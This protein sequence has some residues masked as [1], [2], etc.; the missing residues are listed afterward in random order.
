VGRG[1]RGAAA[2]RRD[3][4]LA[5]GDPIEGEIGDRAGPQ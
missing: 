2:A 4:F 5:P 1:H 3:A